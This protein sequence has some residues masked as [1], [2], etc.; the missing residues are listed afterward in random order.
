MLA[1]ISGELGLS[2]LALLLY[3]LEEYVHLSHGS[4]SSD[5]QELAFLEDHVFPIKR[6]VHIVP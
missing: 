6:K 3:T 4:Y 1:Y 2:C 5:F